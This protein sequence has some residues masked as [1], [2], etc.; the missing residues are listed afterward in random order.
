MQ[1]AECSRVDNIRYIYERQPTIFVGRRLAQSLHA[2]I[3]SIKRKLKKNL[4]QTD[5]LLVNAWLV[6]KVIHSNK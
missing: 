3:F 2:V 5:A 4:E 6:Y 1:A